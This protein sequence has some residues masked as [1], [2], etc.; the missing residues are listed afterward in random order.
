[1]KKIYLTIFA[2]ILVSGVNAQ[3]LT[4]ANHAPT[5]G[6]A[7]GTRQCDSTGITAGANGAGATWN[8][9]TIAI[10]TATTNYNGVTVVSTGSAGAYPSASVAVSAGA[11]KNSFYSASAT[12]LKYWGGDVALGGQN[13]TLAYTSPACHAKYPMSL[14][15]STTTNVSG[16]LAVLGQTGNF[17]GTVTAVGAGTG[18]L[19]LPSV[20]FSNVIKIITTQQFAATVTLI[21]NAS[22][23]QVKYDYYSAVSKAPLFSIAASTVATGFGTTTETL[24]TINSSYIALGVKENSTASVSDLNFYPNP[25]KGN[26]NVSFSNLNGENASYEM[27]NA[28]GQTVKKE[29]LS[30]DKGEVKQNISLDGI[31]SGIYFMKV[32]VGN[33][34][35]VKKIT[36]Q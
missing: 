29:N 3:T 4:Q 10:R 2:A 12:E 14:G 32:I 8:Y 17:V 35:S 23:A 5:V 1:M 15:T 20:N 21:G 22:I 27:I 26:V 25:A 16:T 30:N 28:I 31:E 34:N 36:V 33:N 13:A 19:S 24:V 6:Q 9:S 7:F 18:T 11:G